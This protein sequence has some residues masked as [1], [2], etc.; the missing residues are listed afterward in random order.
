MIAMIEKFSARL[1]APR[2]LDLMKVT[3]VTRKGLLGHAHES[4]VSVLWLHPF[5]S[6]T[7][8]CLGRSRHTTFFGCE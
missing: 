6:I 8:T 1:I 4:C 7:I 3:G 5:G 2:K